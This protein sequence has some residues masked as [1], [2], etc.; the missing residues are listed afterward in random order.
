[1]LN[2]LAEL[3]YYQ[4]VSNQIKNSKDSIEDDLKESR[5]NLNINE[6]I[7]YIIKNYLSQHNDQFLENTKKAHPQ[8]IIPNYSSKGYEV[9]YINS[10]ENDYI[11]TE[12]INGDLNN[13][14]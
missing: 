2:S 6:K 9:G 1:M 4:N 7:N 5:K 10:D 8:L 12:E 11:T 3:L 14:I 13:K